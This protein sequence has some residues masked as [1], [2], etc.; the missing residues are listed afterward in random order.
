MGRLAG[1]VAV[2]SGAGGGIGAATARLFCSETAKVLL[3]DA[4]R[5]AL[6]RKAGG[7]RESTSPLEFDT[8]VADVASEQDAKRAI[9]RAVERFGAVNVLVNNAAIRIPGT[10]EALG[11]SEWDTIL[12]TNLL[13]A[14]N[15][16]RAAVAELRR[17]KAASVV[18]VSSV[19]GVT[20]RKGMGLYDATKAALI[21]LTRTL[22]FEEAEHGIRVNAICPGSTLTDYHLRR[23]AKQGLTEELMQKDP[24]ADSLLRRWARPQE[25]AFPILWL[26]SDE[27]SFITGATLMVDGGLSIM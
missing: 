18:N 4:D 7:L 5:D 1:K 17:A 9:A 6:A 11:R 8:C 12:A 27:A 26:A 20:G 13:G 19:Y 25:I 3:V 21:A 23:G 22:A 16:Y 14:V 10:V 2:I 24:R 15:F